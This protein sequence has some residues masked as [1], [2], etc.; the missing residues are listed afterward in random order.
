MCARVYIALT[1]ENKIIH[2]ITTTT[3]TT[4]AAARFQDVFFLTWSFRVIFSEY[5]NPTR[6]GVQRETNGLFYFRIP[7]VNETDDYQKKSLRARTNTSWRPSADRNTVLLTKRLTDFLYSNGS[8]LYV[9]FFFQSPKE[10]R[11]RERKKTTMIIYAMKNKNEGV[12]ENVRGR[13]FFSVYTP[14]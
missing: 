3:T 6:R 12:V 14:H 5:R 10:T 4:I 9:F 7:N 11:E 8:Y 1:I 13:A 2:N